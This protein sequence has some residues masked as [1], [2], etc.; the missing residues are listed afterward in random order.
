MSAGNN[1]TLLRL[2]ASA[3]LSRR[4]QPRQGLFL[5]SRH[6]VESGKTVDVLRRLR[7]ISDSPSLVRN[8][9]QSIFVDFAG[10]DADQRELYDIPELRAFFQRV[11]LQWPYWAHFALRDPLFIRMLALLGTTANHGM[12]LATP[13]MMRVGLDDTSDVMQ[14]WRHG[15]ERLHAQH[16]VPNRTTSR[17]WLDVEACFSADALTDEEAM[18]RMQIGGRA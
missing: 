10:Y 6:D 1:P 2:R 5:I 3:R 12:D 14:Q 15:L 18:P 7:T 17:I 11:T 4:C 13:T 8:L 16:H 9:P